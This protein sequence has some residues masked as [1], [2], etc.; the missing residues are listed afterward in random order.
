MLT[1][2]V[3]EKQNLVL[4]L[5]RLEADLNALRRK[6]LEA[7]ETA[8]DLSELGLPDKLISQSKR[9]LPLSPRLCSR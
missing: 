7:L 6:Q 3:L 8:L 5:K 2:E 1:F 4:E 9:S